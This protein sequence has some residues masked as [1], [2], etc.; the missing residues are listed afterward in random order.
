MQPSPR[1]AAIVKGS[2]QIHRG[3]GVVV[4]ELDVVFAAPDD[5]HR[6]PGF[7]REEG[8]F[9]GIVGLGLAAE[10]SAEESYVAGDIFFFQAESFG[11]FFLHALR[12]LRRRPDYD[13]LTLHVSNGDRRF[14]GGVGEMRSEIFRFDDFSGLGKFGIRIAGRVYD[15]AGLA[16]ALLQLL[17]VGGGVVGGVGA[18]VPFD[19]EILAAF[20]GGESVIRDDRD[21]AERLKGVRWFKGIDR[22]S[23]LYADHL[24]SGGVIE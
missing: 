4:V 16:R 8:G 24:K 10:A 20:E 15:F 9:D 14:H 3:D 21:A 19:L 22:N 6:L 12:V 23:F 13:F 11:D 1:L 5:F 2:L 7:L 17:L 18:V